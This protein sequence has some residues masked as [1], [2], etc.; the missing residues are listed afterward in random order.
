M[1]APALSLDFCSDGE[2]GVEMEMEMENDSANKGCNAAQGYTVSIPILSV[3]F[4]ITD[5]QLD[6]LHQ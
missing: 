4:P 6:C 1:G 5:A 3:R 2:V